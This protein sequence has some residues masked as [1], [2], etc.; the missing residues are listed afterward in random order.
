[1]LRM[2]AYA[3]FKSKASKASKASMHKM[4]EMHAY[5]AFVN[6]MMGRSLI[7]AEEHSVWIVWNQWK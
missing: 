5:D 3:L 7:C 2:Q 4:Q 6:K 1:M